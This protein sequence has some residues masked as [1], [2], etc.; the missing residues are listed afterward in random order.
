MSGER[1]TMSKKGRLSSARRDLHASTEDEVHAF[2]KKILQSQS[3]TPDDRRKLEQIAEA[4]A[5]KQSLIE[6][7]RNYAAE[8]ARRTYKCE[9]CGLEF[10]G[11]LAFAE[12]DAETSHMANRGKRVELDGSQ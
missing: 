7:V 6:E 5:Q 8:Q 9:M 3:I 1:S 12:H 10:L 4:Q 2:Y 11:I